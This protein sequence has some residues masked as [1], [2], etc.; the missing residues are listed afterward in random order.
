MSKPTENLLIDNFKLRYLTLLQILR[1][2]FAA[3]ACLEEPAKEC[4]QTGF[5]S[6]SQF[7]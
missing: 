2:F 7:G 6:V 5:L 4:G 3:L 1:Q